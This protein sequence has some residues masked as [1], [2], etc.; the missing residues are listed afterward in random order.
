MGV[1][2]VGLLYGAVRRWCGPGRRVCRRCRARAHPGRRAD[3]PLRQS[4]RAAHPAARGGRYA[5]V[6]AVDAVSVQASGW[7]LV[8]GAA[9]GFGFLTKMGQAFLVVPAFGLVYLVAGADPLRTPDPAVARRARRDVVSAGWY[10]ALVELWPAARPARTS[11]GP[12]TTRCWSWPSATTALGRLFGGSGN[13]GAAAGG[14]SGPATP[15]SAAPPGSPGCSP[16]R[17][18]PEVSWLLPAALSRSWP[19]CGSPARAAHRPAARRAAAVG[20]LDAR[21]RP[22]VQLHERHDA[23]VLHGRAGAGHRRAGRRSARSRCGGDGRRSSRAGVLGA[24]GRGH[25]RLGLRAPGGFGRGL[26]VGAVGRPRRGRRRGRRVGGGLDPTG[27]G[28]GR[29]GG[30]PGGPRGA[31][32]PTRWRPPRRR[33]AAPIPTAGT[34]ASAMGGGPGGGAGAR[35]AHGGTPPWMRGATPPAARGRRRP[36]R[37]GVGGPAGRAAA[38]AV[39][40]ALVTALLRPTT[41]PWSAAVSARRARRRWTGERYRGDVHRR[42]VGLRSGRDPRP[43]PG[44]RH[45]RARSTTTSAG[46]RA[47]APAAGRTAPAPDRRLGAGELLLH[48]R[49]RPDRLRPHTVRPAHRRSGRREGT[50]P[51]I[52]SRK[53]AFAAVT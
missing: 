46:A 45:R 3:V 19:G 35:A 13:G 38:W 43:V 17:S 41:S 42:L 27:R 12:P 23:P 22:G 49:R 21:H 9:V 6:R 44:R 36:A 16:A 20:R 8:A 33:T 31:P 2:A 1:A 26:R 37:A 51:V 11:A 52:E 50:F 30:R 4:R 40:P 25:G 15:R 47:V 53:R 48:H 10:V 5:V 28:R 34:S 14:A 39:R 24:G 7:L 29:R 32:A 18:A